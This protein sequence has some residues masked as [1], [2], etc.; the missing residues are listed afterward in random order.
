MNETTTEQLPPPPPPPEPR[1]LVRVQD[2]RVFG[3]VCAGLGRYF[4][5]DPAIFRIAALVSAFFGGAGLLAYVAALLIIPGEGSDASAPATRGG[6]MGALVVVAA[7]IFG[8]PLVF[9]LMFSVGAVVIPLALLVGAGVLVWWLA[10]GEGPQGS[11]GEVA[12]HAI[13]GI[14]VLA[15]CAVTAL[16]GAW[17]AAAGGKTPVAIAVIAAGVAILVGAFARPIRWLIF[18]AVVLALSAGTVAAADVNLDGGI[19]DRS[20]TPASMADVQDRYEL[21]VGELVLDLTHV[22]V[23][24]GD[25]TV[26]VD[27][28]VG[29]ARVYLPDA[30][31]CAGLQANVG[32]GQASLYD[33]HN[34]GVDVEFQDLPDAPATTPRLHIDGDVGVG[35]LV[36]R[37]NG[38]GGGRFDSNRRCTA[39]SQR[40]SR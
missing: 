5:V 30:E 8:L 40:A 10:S 34:G 39:G 19:G 38:V 1:R 22:Q 14:I 2:G 16:A 29:S 3:G 11:A 23:P 15:F 28:G 32:I 21:G 36:V 13:F 12:K 9:A 25:T 35:T 26:K 4:N 20:F 24:P 18:P 27:V 7:L 33:H 17:A 31:I 6:W 37:G